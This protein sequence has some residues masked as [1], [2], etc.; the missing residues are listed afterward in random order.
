MYKSRQNHESK[1]LPSTEVTSILVDYRLLSF[2]WYIW[3]KSWLIIVS[4]I[5][6]PWEIDFSAILGWA[7]SSVR[8]KIFFSLLKKFYSVHPPPNHLCAQMKWPM[9]MTWF[10]IINLVTLLIS[11]ASHCGW[12]SC[13]LFHFR[14]SGMQLSLVISLTVQTPTTCSQEIHPLTKA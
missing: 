13:F 6:V 5:K 9:I 10:V 12:Y 11:Y 3:S 14:I 1:V 2:F 4:K 7:T 8:L